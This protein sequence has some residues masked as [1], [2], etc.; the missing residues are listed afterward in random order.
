MVHLDIFVNKSYGF[1]RRVKNV[2]SFSEKLSLALLFELRVIWNILFTYIQLITTTTTK[3]KKNSQIKLSMFRV[4]YTW[5]LD[6]GFLTVRS[7]WSHTLQITICDTHW[8]PFCPFCLAYTPPSF[9]QLRLNVNLFRLTLVAHL[10]QYCLFLLWV[11]LTPNTARENK[12]TTK[13]KPQRNCPLQSINCA[14]I[15]PIAK[16]T[17]HSVHS[18]FFGPAN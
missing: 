7:L 9:F 5:I 4:L 11:F 8:L 18:T 12:W 3:L 14:R 2:L 10:I 1:F 15:Q 6:F 16:H 13:K 17:R